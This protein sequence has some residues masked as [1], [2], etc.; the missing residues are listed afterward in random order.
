LFDFQFFEAS[1]ASAAARLKERSMSKGSAITAILI[2]FLGGLAIGNLVSS[3]KGGDEDTAI[4]AEGADGAG[5]AAGAGGPAEE[6]GPERYRVPV[7]AD[8]PSKGPADA[9]VTIVEFSD[10]ECPFCS[11]VGPTMQQIMNDYRGKVRIVWRNNPLP[12]HQNAT[13][14]AM[15]A[16]E[17]FTQGGSEK[18]WRMHDLMFA[19]QRALSRT[20]LEGYAQ[21]AGLD[22]AKFRAAL[23]GNTHR[24]KIDADMAVARQI[25]A[26]GT[27][28]FYI[29]GRQLMGAQPFDA[30]KTVIEDEIR[31]AEALVA[32]GVARNRVYAQLTRNGRTSPAP[33]PAAPGADAPQPPR[34][35]PDPA[36]VYRV[37]VGAS[38]SKGPADALVT[39]VIIS[40]FQCPFCKRVEPTLGELATA[41]GR[42]IRFV[43]KNNPLPFH[44][45][46]QNAANVAMFANAQGKF[47]QLHDVLFENQQALE[48]DKLVEY[49]E[50]VGLNGAQARAAMTNNQFQAAIQADMD[51][52]RSLG[53]SG[54]PSFFING[55]NLR[56]A[57]PVAAFKALIDEEL[58][59]AR[60]KVEAGTPRARVYEETIRNG[61]TE[62]QFINAPGGAAPQPAA[63]A[64]DADRVYNIAVPAGAPKKGG[65]NAR[66]VIQQ[67]S[68]YQ[69]PFCSRVE[70]TVD[71]ILRDYGDRVQVV[72]RDFP[73]PFHNNAMPAA[74]AA[75]EA[76][77]QG[78]EAKFWEFHKK[79]F[80]NQRTLERADLERFA[81]EIGGINMARFRAALDNHTHKAAVEADITAV[82][83]AGAQIS[84]PSFFIN[85]RLLQN[86]QPFNAFKTTIDRALA[87]PAR[88]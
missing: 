74:E 84:T 70:P 42:D 35:T 28:G 7:T 2:A 34:R 21:Q 85:D 44:N 53:A 19:N 52:A 40:E 56:G 64:P 78:G 10:F 87:E 9:L 61:A 18:F 15:A 47:W 5:E 49:A 29:N 11:R 48:I 59:K 66:V 69:C 16:V 17:A 77:A 24:A 81:T 73:L 14:A 1:T 86:A 50:Q 67:F 54:T 4:A 22:M 43:W 55:R 27:P 58:A 63:A 37:P 41:Y 76:L 39:V 33:E 68:D 65:R 71:Q 88:R 36:A 25:G 80:E 26:N 20:D 72:W 51:L 60:A 31:R 79:L 32:T 82:T 57:Q 45:N 38:P 13:P 6:G 46:A 3:G 62:A 23:D 8:Q 83:A 75:R 12:F 30:F